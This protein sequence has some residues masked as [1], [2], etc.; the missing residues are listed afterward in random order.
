MTAVEDIGDYIKKNRTIEYFR[1]YKYTQD[2]LER[3]ASR[4]GY[5]RVTAYAELS[6]SSESLFIEISMVYRT[7]SL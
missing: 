2:D 1:S 5:L 6:D 7:N 3:M 4:A